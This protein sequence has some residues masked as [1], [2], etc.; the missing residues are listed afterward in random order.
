AWA[1]VAGQSNPSMGFVGLILFGAWLSARLLAMNHVSVDRQRWVLI[2]GGIALALMAGTIQAGVL[3]PLQLI[4]GSYTP[5]LR[6]AGVVLLMLVA[7]LWGRGLALATDL[8]RD[9]VIGHIALSASA[10]AAVLVF[11]PLTTAVQ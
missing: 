4:I 7:Y 8:N 5:D 1:E 2:G 10:L 9:R 6:G 11:L 3:I